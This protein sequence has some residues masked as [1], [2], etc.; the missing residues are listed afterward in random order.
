MLKN[1]MHN[2]YSQYQ[3]SEDTKLENKYIFTRV[4]VAVHVHAHVIII[5]YNHIDLSCSLPTLDLP[6]VL[7]TILHN[8]YC[9]H[10][11]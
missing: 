6:I 2:Y 10:A 1:M 8:T 7:L 4:T 5:Y 9:A 11:A 3:M